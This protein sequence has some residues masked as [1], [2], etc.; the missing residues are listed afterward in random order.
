MAMEAI[1]FTITVSFLFLRCIEAFELLKA[2]LVFEKQL[3]VLLIKLDFEQ[4][5]LLVWGDTVGLN[6][7]QDDGLS[8]RDSQSDLVKRCLSC[9]NRLL[10]DTGVLKA[11]YVAQ[12]GDRSYN[13][14]HTSVTA[15]ALKRFRHRFKKSLLSP[16][17][18]KKFRWATSDALKLEKLIADLRDLIDKI[19]TTVPADADTQHQRI[20]DDIASCVDDLYTLELLSEACKDRYPT[21]HK[22]AMSAIDTSECGT[23]ADTSSMTESTLSDIECSKPTGPFVSTIQPAS[24]SRHYQGWY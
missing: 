9:I 13:L 17:P 3:E 24:P 4:E 11:R 1:S 20:G 22:A 12:P 14:S 2:T 16:G 15:S 21:F 8:V 7:S 6:D 19:T 18:V 23:R 10:D 5:R